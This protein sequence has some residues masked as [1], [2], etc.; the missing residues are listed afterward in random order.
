MNKWGT[1]SRN[2]LIAEAMSSWLDVGLLIVTADYE[3]VSSGLLE[4][5]KV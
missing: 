4:F 1:V 3:S 2:S 5:V